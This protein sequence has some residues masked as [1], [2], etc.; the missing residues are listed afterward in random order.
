MEGEKIKIFGIT[1]IH[2]E[3]RIK[4]TDF[5]P[6]ISDLRA[7]NRRYWYNYFRYNN[8]F[9]KSDWRLC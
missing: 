5:Q 9:P 7:T 1:H 3:N 6:R 2:Y 4:L 8:I